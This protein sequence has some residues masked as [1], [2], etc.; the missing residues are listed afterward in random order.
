MLGLTQPRELLRGVLRIDDGRHCLVFRR[1]CPLALARRRWPADDEGAAS[2]GSSFT[3]ARNLGDG[4]LYV[5]YLA[6]DPR[7]EKEECD[8]ED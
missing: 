5:E 7:E 8:E 1:W 3:V 2:T 6:E 4:V